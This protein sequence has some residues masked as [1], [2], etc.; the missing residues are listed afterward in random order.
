MLW[1]LTGLEIRSILD[2]VTVRFCVLPPNNSI[3][4]VHMLKT[5]SIFA[6]HPECSNECISG[7][8]AALGHSYKLKFFDEEDITPSLL[9]NTHIVA[10]PGG[11]GDASSYDRFFR[12]KA[13]NI[14]ADYVSDGGRYLGICMGAYWAGSYYFDIL[15][16]VEPVQYIKRPNADIRRSYGTTANVT[17]MQENHD[18]YFYDG[19]ALIGDTKKF[20]TIATYING[21]PMAIIQNRIGLIGCHLESE[22]FW[23]KKPWQY[24][25]SK[26]HKETHHDKLLE[27]VDLLS[28]KE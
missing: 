5:I 26:W 7:M 3:S 16:S 27:F 10:F 2:G 18:M 17:W 12:R 25:G 15:D 6:H 23:Y 1:K 11:I 21:D 20:E 14:I 28:E 19:C 24:I 9:K 4:V 8:S 22:H 13:Q